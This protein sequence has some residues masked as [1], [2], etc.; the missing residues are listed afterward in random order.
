MNKIIKLVGKNFKLLIRSKFS[1]LV[2]LIGPLLI[3]ILAGMAFN[4]T[5]VYKINIGVYSESY[6]ELTDS[7]I[8]KLRHEQFT[9]L[10]STSQEQCT[11][12]I[13][14]GHFHICIVFPSDLSVEQDSDNQIEFYV[15]YSRINIVYMVI[16]SIS[17]RISERTDELSLNM[18]TN[19]LDKIKYTQSELDDKYDLLTTTISDNNQISTDVEDIKTNLDSMDLSFNRGGF[20]TSEI[21]DKST[22]IKKLMN[23]LGNETENTTDAIS[24]I[25]DDL[26]SEISGLGNV[27]SAKRSE[28]RSIVSDIQA[29]LGNLTEDVADSSGSAKTKLISIESLISTT[30][31]N[32][33]GL[34]SR[35]T[36][37]VTL[38][39]T[40]Q[41]KLETVKTK[42][43]T[44]RA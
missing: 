30:V 33:D 32:L 37:A 29:D 31:S 43:S 27:S 15:D 7:F 35:L 16:D 2:I 5:N 10:K 9:V 40:T 17:S 20:K 36:S 19:V 25:L 42:L 41:N 38:R 11:E 18:T 39:S 1:A 8:E 12:K 3:M 14:E 4:N 44:V 6:S 24:L 21:V 26:D 28:L 13:K 34:Q 23:D 22:E